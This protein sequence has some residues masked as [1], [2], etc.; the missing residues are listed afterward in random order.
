MLINNIYLQEIMNIGRTNSYQ[1]NILNSLFAND[2]SASNRLSNEIGQN[3]LENSFL[4]KKRNLER[5]IIYNHWKN[6]IIPKKETDFFIPKKKSESLDEIELLKQS[7]FKEKTNDGILGLNENI[8]NSQNTQR[9]NSILENQKINVDQMNSNKKNIFLE[10]MMNMNSNEIKVMKNNKIVYANNIDSFSK[11]NKI[12]NKKY[13]FEIRK[14]NR[15]SKY[16]GVSKNGNQWQV[17]IMFRNSKS[18]IGTY[19]SEELAARVYDISAIKNKG[20]KAITNFN[21]SPKQINNILSNDID[22][23]A[24]NINLIILDLLKE[25]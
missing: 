6:N 15:G 20:V 3:N 11:I 17:L 16:R 13:L 25:K 8:I 23:K 10:E 18:Y 2:V 14:R 22:I 12:R 7:K 21:Y 24:K 5:A 9:K 4:Q 19:S 1:I